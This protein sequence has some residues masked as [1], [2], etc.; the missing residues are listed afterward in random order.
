[1]F[2]LFRSICLIVI[3]LSLSS[4]VISLPTFAA[5]CVGATKISITSIFNISS[6]SPVIPDSCNGAIGL[7]SLPGI[8]TRGY[9]LMTAIVWQLSI[10][11]LLL[12]GILWIWNGADS[13]QMTG[14]KKNF[15][16]IFW[17]LAMTLGAYII[18]N[19]I[20]TILTGGKFDVSLDGFFNFNV[21]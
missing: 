14:I 19:T 9:G 11:F 4:A 8:L 3:S 12:N 16:K 15:S 6:F 2:K 18:V 21:N 20:V 1:M 17:A 13:N 7:D 10:F 5:G